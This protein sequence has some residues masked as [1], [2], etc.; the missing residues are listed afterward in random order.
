MNPA[1]ASTTPDTPPAPGYYRHTDGGFYQ[2][3]GMARDSRDTS[4][5]V[6]YN[7]VWPFEAGT[8]TRPLHEWHSRFKPISEAEVVQAKAGDR[9]ALQ[10]EVSARRL[11]R[12]GP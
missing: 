5:V 1:T 10:R 7:H 2:V 11:A 9:E 8:W 6:I 12:K 4:P 3:T